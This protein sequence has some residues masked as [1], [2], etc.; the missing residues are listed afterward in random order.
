MYQ[1]KAEVTRKMIKKLFQSI[2]TVGNPKG[3]KKCDFS[4]KGS[5]SVKILENKFSSFYIFET[6]RI[7]L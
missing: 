5:T 4:P 3:L 6:K 1:S 7:Q 2:N